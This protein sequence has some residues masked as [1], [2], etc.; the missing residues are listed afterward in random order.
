MLLNQKNCH[1]LSTNGIFS[2][3]IGYLV[4]NVD[5]ELELLYS[6]G[7]EI[8]EH[9]DRYYFATAHRDIKDEVFCIVDVEASGPSVETHQIIEIA[10]IKLQNGK[11]I[12]KFETLVKCSDI[13]EHITM[14]TSIKA[15]DT[16][17]SPELLD[18]MREFRVFLADSTFVAHSADFDYKYISKTLQK[19]NIGELQN[20]HLCTIKL[21]ERLIA[22]QRYGLSYLNESLSLHVDA[23]HHRAMSDVITTT[24]LFIK[25]L[26]LLPSSVK[27]TEE[28]IYFSK[29]ALKIPKML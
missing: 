9:K 26:E 20:R 5:Y 19:L 17:N 2:E 6:Q 3:N 29:H 8:L 21:A 24:R 1:K 16:Q 13:S 7:L 12:D 11:I 22:S 10:A 18:V 28:L 4:D 23:T 14:I 27:T 25:L 15:T